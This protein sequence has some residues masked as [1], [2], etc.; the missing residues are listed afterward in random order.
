M[1]KKIL[2][3]FG[4]TQLCWFLLIGLVPLTIAG[5]VCYFFVK[6]QI[7]QDVFNELQIEARGMQKSIEYLLSKN[8]ARI[9]GFSSDGFI[10]D[11]TEALS[12]PDA[13]VETIRRG[14][15]KHLE[16][17]KRSLDPN[18][19]EVF[20]IDTMGKVVA[21]TSEARVG[22]DV[23]G[24]QYF[25]QPF[26]HFEQT[27]PLFSR[28]TVP[29]E[30]TGEPD[31][32]FSTLITD[33]HLHT[34]I[35]VI[36]NRVSIDVLLS[37][38]IASANLP[39]EE[40]KHT[41]QDRIYILNE[42]KFILAV[43]GNPA[44]KHLKEF[45]GT[46]VIERALVENKDVIDTYKNP[47]GHRVLAVAVPVKE[48]GWVVL[49][50]RDY[51]VAFAPL[52]R[53]RNLFIILNCS[54]ALA[55]LL[56]SFFVSRNMSAAIQKFKDGTETVASGD[57]DHRIELKRKDE[58]KDLSL[59]FNAMTKKLKD[60]T[61]ER[62][63]R[64]EELRR[65]QKQLFQAEKMSSLGILASGIAH[66]I[67]NPLSYIINNTELVKDYIMDIISIKEKQKDKKKLLSIL[68]EMKAC[69]E[70]SKVGAEQ[71]YRTVS[72]VSEF[73]HPGQ[74]VLGYVDINKTMEAALRV[75]WHELRHK[76]NITKD[77][78]K[79]PKIQCYP[80]YLAQIFTNLLV[81]AAHAIPEYGE[82][83]I[84][85]YRRGQTVCIEI[86]DTGVGIP[87]ENLKRVFDPFFTT[88]DVGKGTGLGLSIVYNLVKQADG[89]IEATSTVGKGATFKVTLP[90]KTK[91]DIPK[92]QHRQR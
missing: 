44:S 58:L 75:A 87:E 77:Y 9:A 28:E 8:L 48:T 68:E 36:A 40:V 79:L 83:R 7:K 78:A 35:G 47:W 4:V 42:D 11:S 22:V 70:D 5:T 14:L 49:A 1:P 66:E 20:V 57:L 55:A 63:R 50:E 52:A 29:K 91:P 2:T 88:K 21:A 71:I 46:S 53:I 59:S 82:I 72:A 62:A 64:E 61:E 89:N 81:N 80:H 37:T 6:A 84:K 41:G 3:R 30:D 23:S 39:D 32:V 31:L 13:D 60:Y 18:I 56:V 45:T 33:K 19:V 86:S 26:L 76:A 15:N 74:D 12:L 43:S 92:A 54:A 17:N 34:P 69:L 24:E 10:R 27:G 25:I 90:L 73:S 51:K 65:T 16:V 38:I 85:T 67:N